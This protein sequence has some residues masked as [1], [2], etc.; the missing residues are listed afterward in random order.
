MIS[1]LHSLFNTPWYIEK[2]YGDSQLPLLFGILEGKQ[3]FS[4]HEK[5]PIE[6][7]LFSKKGAV[8]SQGDGSGQ[9]VA[10]VSLKSPIFKY[11][12]ECG[13]RGTK[14]YIA[15]LN[16]LKNNPD[17]SGVV[18]DIDSGGG[19][20]YGTPEFHDFLK[21]YPKPVVAYTDGLLASAAYYIASGADHI[22]A[23]R[24]ADAIGSI[25]AYAEFLDLTGY[26]E[27]KGAKVHTIYAEQS[28][29]KNKSYRDI[30]EG[31]YDTYI[32]EDLNPTVD[33][34]VQDIKSTRSKINKSVFK[35]AIYNA[36]K[37]LELNLI[38]EIGSLETAISKVFELSK[39]NS[40]SNSKNMNTK[41]FPQIQK[42]LGLETP[43]AMN[44]NGSFLNEEQLQSL[45][46]QLEQAQSNLQDAEDARIQAEQALQTA[47]ETHALEVQQGTSVAQALTTL[48]SGIA[49]SAGVEG[50]A[51]DATSE[52][53]A[54]AI[55]ERIAVLNGKPGA[56][57]TTAAEDQDPPKDHAYLD[58][59]N[60]IYNPLKQ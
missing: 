33:Q 46:N 23:N 28:T 27:K 21:E 31:N 48:L 35:G 45:E 50:L 12:Q 22:V 17:V 3:T 9:Y 18:L 15:R 8:V 36:E 1:N 58:F 60:S 34:F 44:D 47:N 6:Q 41:E 56:G 19:Q 10:V 39:Q 40:K 13:P 37:A 57:H 32:K 11:D 49:E 29:E 53:V 55:N 59:E 52:E 54:N 14:S 7:Q 38:D 24:R 26:Y 20:V 51:E 25:G 2:A 16:A 4:N 43:L 42:A 30:L 5:T